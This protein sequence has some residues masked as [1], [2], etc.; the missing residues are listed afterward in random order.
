[1][2]FVVSL[3]L[4]DLSIGKRWLNEGF[5]GRLKIRV[6]CWCYRSCDYLN[7]VNNTYANDGLHD[8]EE[9]LLVY[10]WRIIFFLQL[11]DIR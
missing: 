11:L 6:V 4:D 8:N 10:S 2:L 5:A 9:L 7:T 1:M 3:F